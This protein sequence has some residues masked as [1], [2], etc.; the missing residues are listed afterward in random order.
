ML[1]KNAVRHTPT[2]SSKIWKQRLTEIETRPGEQI[3][4]SDIPELTV[5]QCGKMKSR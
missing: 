3:D 4:I 5:E 2:Q 1:K